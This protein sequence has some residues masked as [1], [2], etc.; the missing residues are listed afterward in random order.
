M[1]VRA[2]CPPINVRLLSPQDLGDG[3]LS[4]G[5]LAVYRDGGSQ[6]PGKGIRGS[7]S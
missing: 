4:P 2:R 5:M 1:H 6:S 3:G 7:E